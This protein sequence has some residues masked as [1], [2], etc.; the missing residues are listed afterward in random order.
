MPGVYYG[1]E[2]TENKKPIK[3]IINIMSANGKIKKTKWG[4]SRRNVRDCHSGTVVRKAL[5]EEVTFK[6]RTK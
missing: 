3:T 4:K 2:D 5:S 1:V 6:L